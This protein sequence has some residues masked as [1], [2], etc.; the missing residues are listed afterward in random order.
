MGVGASW[1][2]WLPL[3]SRALQWSGWKRPELAV[4]R[5]Q[6]DAD[7]CTITIELMLPLPPI[8]AERLE[9]ELQARLRLSSFFTIFSIVRTDEAKTAPPLPLV[10]L[11]GLVDPDES[12]CAISLLVRPIVQARPGALLLEESPAPIPLDAILRGDAAAGAELLARLR[13][14]SVARLVAGDELAACLEE[15]VAAM[16][17]FF[18][19]SA[20]AKGRVYCELRPGQ[21]SCRQYAGVG[22]DNGREWVQLRR[23][24]R[25]GEGEHGYGVAP[26]NAPAAFAAAY[27]ALRQASAAC[28]RSLALGL[29]LA[30]HAWLALT[31]LADD[32]NAAPATALALAPAPAG[33]A[34]DATRACGPSV[35]RLYRYKAAEAQGCGCHAHADLGMLTLSAAPRLVKGGAEAAAAAGGGLHVFDSEALQW[36][37]AEHGLSSREISVFC[38]EQLALLSNGQLPAPVH[39]V[40]PPPRA[41]GTRYSLPFFVRAHPDAILAPMGSPAAARVCED[42]VLKSLFRRRPWRPSVPIDDGHTPDY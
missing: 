17:A 38:G 16:P 5:P 31:D 18:A 13:R 23:R 35:L 8:D 15:C 25:P 22:H 3:R 30:P 4:I 27:E 6:T 24:A 32:A 37:E 11:H 34:G 12:H 10:L 40:P 28:L 7:E 29:G 20:Q 39:R 14:G 2:D 26:D 33:S 21:P 19:Q 42:F 9:L 36:A 41:H 1:S